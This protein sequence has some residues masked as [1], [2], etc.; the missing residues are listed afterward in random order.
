MFILD[1]E[2]RE[3]MYCIY[4]DVCLSSTS[5]VVKIGIFADRKASLVDILDK[6]KISGS[7]KK[8]QEK[9]KK[10]KKVVFLT[11]NQFFKK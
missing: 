2:R 4:N 6:V 5:R 10:V 3:R 11:Q 1:S 7:F 8:H 9:F